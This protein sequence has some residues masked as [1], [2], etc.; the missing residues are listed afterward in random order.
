MPSGVENRALLPTPSVVPP[1]PANPAKVLTTPA[2]VIFR[3][4]AL[5]DSAT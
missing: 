5:V 2:G 3:I 4:V 1:L